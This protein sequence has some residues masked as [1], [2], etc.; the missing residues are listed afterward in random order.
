MEGVASLEHKLIAHYVFQINEKKI[1][2]VDIDKKLNYM[3]REKI[4]HGLIQKNRIR[5]NNRVHESLRNELI[6]ATAKNKNIDC[7]MRMVHNGIEI[8]REYIEDIW[9]YF[10]E[11]RMMYYLIDLTEPIVLENI[12]EEDIIIM[13]DSYK[14]IEVFTRENNDYSIIHIESNIYG[15]IRQFH[16]PQWENIHTYINPKE[17]L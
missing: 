1:R 7:D 8:T 6:V 16:H 9:I 3:V 11:P 2:F 17:E 14:D 15:P 5:F 4:L 10:K 12:E 13:S